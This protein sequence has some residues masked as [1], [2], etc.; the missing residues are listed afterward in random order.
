MAKVKEKQQSKYCGIFRISNENFSRFMYELFCGMK[1]F[2][3]FFPLNRR[4]LEDY[5]ES[6]RIIKKANLSV[7]FNVK[8]WNCFNGCVI[9]LG[10]SFHT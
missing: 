9:F 7:A 1:L 6:I 3:I 10:F 4:T 5:T 2:S 8:A